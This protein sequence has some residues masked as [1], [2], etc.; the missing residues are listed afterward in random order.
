[1]HSEPEPGT[2][3]LTPWGLGDLVRA[4]VDHVYEA[5]GR[6]HALLWLDPA[7]SG[8]I[9]SELTT[10]SVPVDTVEEPTSTA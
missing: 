8:A 7:F 9:L 1:M 4:E 5:P 6:R 10:I 2:Q 3:V